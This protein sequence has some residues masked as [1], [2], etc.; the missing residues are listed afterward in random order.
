M[1]DNAQN[2]LVP[3]IEVYSVEAERGYIGSMF[4]DPIEQP[5]QDW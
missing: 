4:E 2:Y 3:L 1:M 5:E